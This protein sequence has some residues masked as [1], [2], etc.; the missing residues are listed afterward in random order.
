[1]RKILI[2][3]IAA[4][5][6]LTAPAMARSTHWPSKAAANANVPHANVIERDAHGRATRVMVDGAAYA[7]CS[8]SVTDSCI[9]P[10]QAGLNF[11]NVPLDHWPGHPASEP[12]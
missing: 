6:A 4:S 9:N 8:A 2:V 1:M 11:G 3:G 12:G 7:V 10:R 5:V